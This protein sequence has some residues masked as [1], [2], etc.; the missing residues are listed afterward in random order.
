MK[1]LILGHKGM[2]GHMVLKFLKSKKVTCSILG[3]RWPDTLFQKSIMDF[4]GDFIINCAGA[5]PQKIDEFSINYELPILI[6]SFSHSKC[7][8]IYPGSDCEGENTPYGIS[9]K[10]ASDWIKSHSKKTKIIKTSIIGPEISTKH[11]LLE[12]F[13]SQEKEAGGF[14][15]FYWNGITTLTWAKFCYEMVEDWNAWGKET[16]LHSECISKYS[17]MKAMKIIYK[18][19]MALIKINIPIGDRCLSGGIST[20]NIGEQLKELKN[21]EN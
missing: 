12:W 16:I 14:S 9:K 17:L 21:G 20:P 3:Y 8:I 6:D 4:K 7:K 19:D 1:V 5:I 11:G 10:K 13:L 2:L 15:E 18:K